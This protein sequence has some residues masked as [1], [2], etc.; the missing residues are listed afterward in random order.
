[1]RERIAAV[2]L[3][4]GASIRM[5]Q[6]KAL[7]TLPDGRGALA[8]VLEAAR[9]V[10]DPVLL[11][12]DTATHAERLQREAG[13]D[14]LLIVLDTAPGAGPLLA[15]AGAMRAVDTPALLVLAV[16]TPL[17]EPR[18]LRL[19][20][21]LFL[22]GEVAIVAPCVGGVLQPMPA[23]YARALL[24][25]VERLI[26]DGRRS[27]R[28]LLDAPAARTH[29]IG[30]DALRAID[31]DLRSFAGANTPEEWRRVLALAGDSR[32]RAEWYP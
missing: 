1:M 17:V 31:P 10:A 12:T 21:D 25:T 19:L 14:P 28:A 13:I 26:A 16:D 29:V 30:E 4:G 24:A 32:P 15:L 27:L 8:H 3:A 18:L 2:V 22:S 7:L 23:L 20:H 5:G 9:A 6:E 11:A